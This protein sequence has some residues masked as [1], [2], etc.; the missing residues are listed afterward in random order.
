MSWRPLILDS[1]SNFT[2][3]RSS[4]VIQVSVWRALGLSCASRKRGLCDQRKHRL[5]DQHSLRLGIMRMEKQ[6][7]A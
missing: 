4:N 2:A 7:F 1:S 6:T 5:T 3:P